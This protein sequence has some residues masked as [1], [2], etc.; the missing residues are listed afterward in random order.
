MKEFPATKDVKLALDQYRL[1]RMTPQAGSWIVMQ[2]L[3]KALS[4]N[5]KGAISQANLGALLPEIFSQFSE[6][7]FRSLQAKCFAATARLVAVNDQLV[8]QPLFMQ[9]GTGRWAVKEPSLPEA[10]ALTIHSLVFN[11]EPFFDDGMLEMLLASLPA[12]SPASAPR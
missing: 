8:A 9:D 2:L 3:T 10:L 7:E 5:M 11:L 4:S 6:D 12:L 1:S